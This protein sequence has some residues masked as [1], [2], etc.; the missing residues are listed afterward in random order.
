V[1]R[2]GEDIDVDTDHEAPPLRPAEL[3]DLTG[4]TAVVT[5]ASSGLG[6]RFV[7]V[8]HAAGA[9][10]VAVARRADRLESLAADHPNVVP[11]AADVTDEQAMGDLVQRTVE[12]TGR[13]DLLVNN[14]GGATPTPSVEVS[15]TE[16]R[17]GLELNLVSVFNLSRL[18]AEPMLKAGRGS[19]INIASVLGLGAAWPI[20]SSIYAA[21]KGAVVQLT[22]EL[23]CEWAGRG[24]RVN[25]IAPGFFVTEGTAGMDTD[26]R[27]MKYI[28]SNTPMRRMGRPDELDAAVLFLAADGSTYL[29]GQTIPVDGGWTAH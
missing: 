18:A 2:R 21:A 5:G 26:E 23:A 27:A 11:L 13:L 19:I 8:L 6:N 4:R 22:R 7:R 14:A 17:A 28:T 9:E 20:P 25:A 3:F 10:V 24:V 12:R 15:L 29:T 16:F 1:D